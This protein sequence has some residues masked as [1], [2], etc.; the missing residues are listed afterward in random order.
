M[1]NE[2]RVRIAPSPT[3]DPHVGTAYI[4]L[5]NYVFKKQ[6]NGKMIL[7]IEDT[8]QTR[9]KASSEELIYQSLRWLGL[10]WDEGPDIGGEYGPYRQSERKDIYV[11]YVNK[12]LESGKAYRC[13]CTSER[14][15]TMREEQK[16]KGASGYD[17]HC[18]YLSEE[19]IQK[20]L[21][22][23][24]PYVV[25]LKVPEEGVTT[26]YD[27][28]R[29]DISIDNSTVDDQVLLKSDGFPTYHLANVV[30]DHLM[31]ITHVIRAEE[32]ITSTPKHML[33]YS[34]FGWQHPHWIHM[35]LLRNADKSKISKRKNPVSLVY[36]K[37]AGFLPEAVVNFLALMGWNPGGDVELFGLDEM[38][39]KFNFKNLHLGGPV[40]DI[41][42]LAWMNQHYIQQMNEKDFVDYIRNEIFS[43]NYLKSIYPLMK[44]R[45]SKFEDFISKAD[46]FFNGS[47]NYTE[48][49]LI[50][51]NISK[52][53]L[54]KMFS[55]LLEELDELY[56]WDS[57][58]IEEILHNQQEKLAWK[59]KDYFMPI[60][61]A[62][63]GRKDSP[64]LTETMEVIGRE[65]V[66]FRIKDAITRFLS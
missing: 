59:P 18:R 12:L 28:L 7:R 57:S 50:P 16:K 3:G 21:A 36:Y 43:E 6:Y 41:K 15:A 11:E 37:K 20:K 32:W 52:Q 48:E 53:D 9:S 64:P 13:F 58:K 31:K 17:R 35:P 63:T 66:R 40:F 24:E 49:S 38:I 45:I 39:E 42:K 51:K 61:I 62:V 44:E 47:L 10:N 23:H 54:K 46:F 55:T 19:E 56:E 25:R 27:E 5:F 30:D 65:L 2:V 29:G 4:A 1:D 14:L 8:D 22:N 60:R 26:F 34:A 33:L